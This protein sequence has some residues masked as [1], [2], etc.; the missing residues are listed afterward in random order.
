MDDNLLG[1]RLL[2]I[3]NDP[4]LGRLVKNVAEAAGFEVVFTKNPAVFAETARNWCPSVLM[5]DLGMPGTDGIQL[6][7]ALAE[8]KCGAHLILMSRADV[9]ILEAAMQLGRDRGLLMSGVLEKPV[10][11]EMLRKFLARLQAA[12]TPLADDLADALATHQLFLEY[13]LKLDCRLGRVTG[14]EALVRWSHPTLGILH[15]DQFIP[16]AEES[17]LIHRLTDWVIMAAAKQ[18]AEWHTDNPGLEVAVNIAAKNV[19]DL[20]LPD[21]LHKYCRVAGID[22]SSIT[23]ELTETGAMR[24]ALQMMDVMTRLRL[25]GFKLSIDDFGT[26]F[27]SLV[28]LQKLPFSEV[29]IDRSFVMQ[30]M[31][32]EGCMAIVEI[33]ID[34]ARKL[35]LRSVAEGVEDEA[36]LH[37]LMRLGCDAAQGFYLARPVAADRIPAF[38]CEYQ[39]MRGVF[40]APKAPIPS[41]FTNAR[42]WRRRKIAARHPPIR[43]ASLVPVEVTA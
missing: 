1:N 29:K 36:A 34:L 11:P 26:G 32:N 16:L 5:L 4:A 3:D 28:Q 7:R 37:A 42:A 9:K 22:C 14:V 23:L 6:L 35:G 19:E 20:G 13:Q 39:L 17:D 10:R 33:V 8:D 31:K 30:M 38:L 18:A 12:Q 2:V 27:S 15:P 25:K 24:E 41:P 40:K 43:L 21:R